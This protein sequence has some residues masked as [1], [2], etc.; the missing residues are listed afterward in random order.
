MDSKLD[1]KRSEDTKEVMISEKRDI[2][3]MDWKFQWWKQI[4]GM[5]YGEQWLV[6]GMLE[7]EV[8]KM[9]LLI[10]IQS[11][12]IT[13]LTEWVEVKNLRGWNIAWT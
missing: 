4:V 13:E 2:E 8:L 5:K 9:Q 12:R 6:L 3:S 11:K 1:K 10:M 7:V